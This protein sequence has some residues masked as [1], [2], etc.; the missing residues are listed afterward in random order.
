MDLILEELGR[1]AIRVPVPDR[2]VRFLGSV[3]EEG[4]KIAGFHPMFGRDKALEMT[5]EAWSCL[6]DK[7]HRVLGW[8][9]R[10]PVDRGMAETLRW[11]REEGML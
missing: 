7:A 1:K 10:I 9:S 6:P 8:E 3:V 2:V 11:F 5:Q 4:A